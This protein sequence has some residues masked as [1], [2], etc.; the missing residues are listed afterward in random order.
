MRRDEGRCAFVGRSGRC[1]ERGFLE[2]HHVV[3]FAEHGRATVDNIELRCRAH[4]A[5]EASLHFAAPPEENTAVNSRRGEW[6]QVP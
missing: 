5:Y 1:E 6:K 4:N 3:P 2:L